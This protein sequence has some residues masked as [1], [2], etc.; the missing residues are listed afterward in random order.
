M[1]EVWAVACRKKEGRSSVHG[2]LEEE[3]KNPQVVLQ[4][5]STRCDVYNPVVI[6]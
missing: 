5:L 4:A 3:L 6:T 2:V 1:L